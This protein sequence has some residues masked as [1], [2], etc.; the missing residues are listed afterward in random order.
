MLGDTFANMQ[1]PLKVVNGVYLINGFIKDKEAHWV[2]RIEGD[3]DSSNFTDDI[4]RNNR[5]NLINNLRANLSSN[6]LTEIEEQGISLH[7]TYLNEKDDIL[8]EF[9]FTANDLK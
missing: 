5:L 9:I 4:V 7:Y 2:Y 6:Y 8:F 3:I 1:L